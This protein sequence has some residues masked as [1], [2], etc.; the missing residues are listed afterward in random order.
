MAQ[1]TGKRARAASVRAMHR[2]AMAQTAVARFREAAAQATGEQRAAATAWYADANAAAAVVADKLRERGHA[3]DIRHGAA[4][5]AAFSPREKWASNLVKAGIFAAGE[6]PRGLT[7]NLKAAQRAMLADNPLDA[8]GG[9]KT[10]AFARN[11]AGDESA[12]TVDVWMARAAGIEPAQLS[13]V[14]WYDAIADAVA[15]VA[16]EYGMSPAAMQA[17]IWVVVRGSAA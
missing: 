9:P 14:G 5:I 17:M 2:E 12:V 11:I 7:S 6:T 8:L 3:A 15:Y 16:D 13:R 4:I 10:R 1:A